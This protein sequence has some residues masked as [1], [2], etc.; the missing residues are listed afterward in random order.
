MNN[1]KKTAGKRF[2]F[3]FIDVMLILIILFS[4]AALWYVLTQYGRPESERETQVLGQIEY[5]LSVSPI[6]EEFRGK[7]NVGDKIRDRE[8][9]A[10]LGEVTDVSYGTYPFVG[11]NR[12]T[13]EPVVSAYPGLL[14][15]TV[16]VRAEA[17]MT[18]GFCRI[19]GT[20]ML[21]GKEVGFRVP[22]L[23]ATGICSS[24]EIHTEK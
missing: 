24:L 16:K 1:T 14:T 20:E 10:V 15:M 19:D 22:D 8:T 18:D 4:A 6:R 21:I 2:R 12:D 3:N 5:H 17:D 7:V 9:G 23:Y 13:G 11:T